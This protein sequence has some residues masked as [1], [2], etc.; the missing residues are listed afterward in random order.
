M[1]LHQQP[2][3]VAAVAIRKAGHTLCYCLELLCCQPQ[4]MMT[5]KFRATVYAYNVQLLIGIT[6]ALH[7]YS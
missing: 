6:I 7:L 4:K 2:T 3:E 5:V 1:K